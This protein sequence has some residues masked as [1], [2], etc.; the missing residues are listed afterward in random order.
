MPQVLSK[1]ALLRSVCLFILA[2]LR[3][4]NVLTAII[5]YL[6]RGRQKFNTLALQYFPHLL[7]KNQVMILSFPTGFPIKTEKK[8]S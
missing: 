8:K 4:Q 6:W 1:C 5:E 3:N 7:Y 2:L